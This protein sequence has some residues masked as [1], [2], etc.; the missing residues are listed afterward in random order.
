MY[1]LSMASC[2]VSLAVAILGNH[3]PD[4]M[5]TIDGFGIVVG[6]IVISVSIIPLLGA[7]YLNIKQ[8][9]REIK[10][11]GAVMFSGLLITGLILI[12]I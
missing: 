12:F 4:E 1:G 3:V 5:M 2:A 6:G 10:F 9:S 7:T 8:Q 11:V